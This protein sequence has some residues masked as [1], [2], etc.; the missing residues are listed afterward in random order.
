MG[1]IAR[2]ML[3]SAGLAAVMG[4]AAACAAA[5]PDF[6][7]IVQENRGAVVNISSTEVVN[8]RA[9]GFGFGAPG[10]PGDPFDRFFRSRPRQDQTVPR[11]FVTKSLGSGFIIAANGY[12]LTCAH[13][14]DHAR[15]VIVKLAN[16]HD[17]VARV[18]GLDTKS[19][20]A[21]LK[22]PA[23]HLPTV[24]I[25][26]PSDLQVGDWVLAIGAPFG[27]ENSATAGIVSG[28]GRNL[29]GSDYVPFIQTDVP[30]NPGNSGGPL[31]NAS[32]QVVGIN[33]QIYSRTGG[34]MGLSFAI[35]IDLAM[36]IGD[37]L[38]ATGHVQWAWLGITIQDVTRE[39]AASFDLRKP[40]GALV[41]EVLPNGP[42]AHSPLRV[43]DIIVRYDGHPITQSAD[44]P[45]LV[46]L[47]PIGTRAR[48]TV[49]R[50]GRPQILSVVV[51]ALP[52][53]RAAAAVRVARKPRHSASLG[54]VLR[55]LSDRERR[56]FGVP[57]GV[58]VEGVGDGPG[59]RA[60]IA[61]GD[62][63]VRLGGQPVTS[64][65]QFIALA[66]RI[67]AHHPVPVL[68]HRGGSAMF[69]ALTK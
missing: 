12:V 69:V 48:L 53:P 44:L 21:L 24:T 6:A 23:A 47:T 65:P 3:V 29:P 14:I 30:I 16:G 57:A 31:F 45:P 59:E 5:W 34:F 51:G 38:K 67:P 19:D 41:A 25:G 20:V 27:F 63:I 9:S 17:Y 26:H 56:A 4:Q 32:G 35:P 7:R 8:G 11:R 33:S 42:A 43:G 50:N 10:G 58:F 62:V 37:E 39:L 66:A 60:G 49:M 52:E 18:V 15:R 61:P 54:L 46:G 1:T 64:V 28:V 36:R 13:V 40:Y 68:I 2:R 22:I 55:D